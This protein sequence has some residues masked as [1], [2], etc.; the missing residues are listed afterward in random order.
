M[1]ALG[2]RGCLSRE[3]NLMMA[4]AEWSKYKGSKDSINCSSRRSDRF[5]R[6]CSIYLVAGQGNIARLAG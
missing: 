4:G 6:H 2:L 1:Y 3:E 5:N